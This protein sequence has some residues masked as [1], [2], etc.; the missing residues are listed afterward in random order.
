MR[1]TDGFKDYQTNTFKA[2]FEDLLVILANKYCRSRM[3][4][5]CIQRFFEHNIELIV[6]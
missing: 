5:K 2:G 3:C 6:S 4:E 1:T